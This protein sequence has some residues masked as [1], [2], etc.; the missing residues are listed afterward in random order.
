MSRAHQIQSEHFR[1]GS[2]RHPQRGL[3]IVLLAAAGM[4]FFQLSASIRQYWRIRGEPTW[5]K[6]DLDTGLIHFGLTQAPHFRDT[7]RWLVGP[8]VGVV[9]FYRPLTSYVFWIEW[10]LFGDHEWLYL[11][12]SVGAHVLATCAFVLLVV[13]L[14]RRWG[15][16]FPLL[17][18]ILA[19]AIFTRVLCPEVHASTWMVAVHW[20][21]QPDSLA[22]VF[23]GLSLCA[24][25]AAQERRSRIP[26]IA[27]PLYLAAC[28]FKEIAVP[29]PAICLVLEGRRLWGTERAAAIQRLVTLGLGGLAF[30]AVR[31]WAIGGIGYVY[32]TNH[33]WLSRTLV[34]GLGPFGELAVAITSGPLVALWIA[35]VTAVAI[36]A[37]RQRR[38]RNLGRARILV[39][40]I[41]LV[42]L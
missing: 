23:C 17:T 19:A 30:L 12:P 13:H 25:L 24:Y 11:I 41:L 33:A 1:S 39:R 5:F 20:K 22:T 26:W 10:K 34:N 21:N 27:L 32:G 42:G 40:A 14:A 9:P 16:R 18:G 2:L 28:G 37:F 4:A 15:T 31:R 6:G 38:D 36:R 29:L 7:L 3:L 35:A 8:W